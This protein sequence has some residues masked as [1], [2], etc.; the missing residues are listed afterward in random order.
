MQKIVQIGLQNSVRIRLLSGINYC[1]S[2]ILGSL[3]GFGVFLHAFL[4][5]ISRSPSFF[6]LR[7]IF[8]PSFQFVSVCEFIAGI[9]DTGEE[10]KDHIYISEF[11]KCEMNEMPGK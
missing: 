9:T 5:N 6:Y 8:F 3:E 4:F 2:S 11:L 1:T 7:R 10:I